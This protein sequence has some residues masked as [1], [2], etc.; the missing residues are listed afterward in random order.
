MKL[1]RH[2]GT[3]ACLALLVG[4]GVSPASSQTTGS[5]FLS[6]HSRLAKVGPLGDRHLSY[7]DPD[8]AAPQIQSLYI[9]PVARFPAEARFDG[10]D[11]ALVAE[12]LAYAGAQLRAQLGPRYKLTDSPNDADATLQVAL[13][14]LAAQPEGK[15]ALDLVPLRLITGPVKDAALGKSLEVAATFEIRLSAPG[16]ARP[17]REAAYPLKSKPIGR[18]NNSKTHITADALKPAIERWSTALAEQLAAKP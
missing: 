10:I 11:D 1:R 7:T 8:V 2:I 13:T 12:L 18:A 6:N 15:T 3:L 14:G 17:W 5:G 16:A 9:L 4:L